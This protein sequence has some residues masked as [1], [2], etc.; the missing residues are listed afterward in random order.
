MKRIILSVINDLAT[1]QRVHRI[2]STLHELGNDVLVVGRI[3]PESLPLGREYNTH[4]ME[5]YFRR[6]LLFYAIF[7]IKLFFL[8]LFKKVDILV[9]NDLDTLPANFLVSVLRRKKLVYDTHEYFTGMP[10]LQTRPVAAV[11]WKGLER[12]MLPHIKYI[13]T[14]NESIADLY[15]KKYKK[16]VQ[17]VRN[18]P[19]RIIK[20]NWPCRKD[21]ELPEDKK[22]IILQGAGININRGAEEAIQTMKFLEGTILLIIGGGDVIQQLKDMVVSERLVS[23]VMFKPKMPYEELMAY[24][25]LADLG[26]TLD[27]DT[28]I[29]YRLSL[30]NKLFDYIQAQIPVMCSNLVEVAGIVN[31]REL[32]LVAETHDP[33]YLAEMIEDMFNDQERY[34]NW[35]INLAKAA[36]ELN[37]DKEKKC[38]IEIYADL[39]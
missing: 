24:T 2:A 11:F 15:R 38:L 35:K 19:V 5:C 37:W 20:N 29:N 26:I 23:K 18:V 9:S 27:K 32:G 17:V 28:N 36:D 4:R 33:K 8:I 30:P 16:K 6:G 22:I 14:V 34:K 39:L 7:N 21:L 12:I 31:K 25:R 13:Y 3:L 10:E 1:D